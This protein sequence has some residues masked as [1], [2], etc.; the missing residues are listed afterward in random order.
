MPYQAPIRDLAFCLDHVVG[1][2]QL[3]AT[4]R[5]AE[6]TAETRS[7][8][9][10]EAGKLASGVLAP[11][12]RNGDLHPAK[13][14]NGVV[15][16][17][18]GFADAYRQIA[19][20]GWVG[21][22]ADPEHGGM[23]LPLTLATAMGEMFASANLALSL[24]PLLSQGQIEALEAH[25]SPE[26][27][28][29]YL[30]KLTS[31]EWTGTMN[32]TEPQAGSDVGAATTKAERNDDGSYAI[33]GQKIYISWGDHDVAEN[34]CH[35]VLA[36]LP[37]APAGTRG[38]SLFLVPKYIP[39]ADGN[40]GEANALRVVSLE[41]K[42][43]IHGSPTAVMSYE[44]AKGWVVGPEGGGIA[45]MF[46][47]MNNA[48]LGVGVEGLGIAEAAYQK[49]LEYAVDRVQGRT[50]DG[51]K[52]IIGHA[53]VRRMLMRM[54]ALTEV[55]RAIC[56]DTALSLDMAKAAPKADAKAWFARGAFLTP[57]AKAFGTDAGM[58]V[59]ELGIQVHGGMGFIE[60]TGAAQFYRD[61]R[62]TAIYEGTNG[63]QAADLV[64]RKLADG[65]TAADGL[66]RE[67][68]DVAHAAAG[69]LAEMG[70]QLAVGADALEAATQWMLAAEPNDRN[71]G[72]VDYLRAWALALGGS[73]L[74]K[75][76]AA[77]TGADA[78]RRT[79]LARYFFGREFPALDALCEAA[80][81]GAA[82]LYALSAEELAS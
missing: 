46:T 82:P 75:G 8:I 22:A 2:D 24:C 71:A 16:T 58:E 14:E 34:V 23:G 79:A 27:Q 32:L 68:R 55:A 41:H 57:I 29:L 66:L 33:T 44:G 35:L 31:G 63:V 7:A 30:P 36:R 42:M 49:A 50:A 37:D 54:K 74:L 6:A 78:D 20:G 45:C 65:G 70:G 3:A 64:G 1:A 48:R 25:A 21:I 69:D 52:T 26:M 11:I 17:S 43:G 13:L 40:P 61:V 51:S 39:D 19:E 76:A 60:E 47:M 5:F 62:V 72:S 59:A 15:R 67:I 38:L 56:L 77:A 81:D 10:D 28:A 9:L 4:E 53:D 18:P 73:Y 12:N 80:M